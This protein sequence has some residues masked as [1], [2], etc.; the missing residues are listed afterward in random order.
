MP[1]CTAHRLPTVSLLSVTCS[2]MECLSIEITQYLVF[3]FAH[4]PLDVLSLALASKTMYRKVLGELGRENAYDRDQHCAVGGVVYCVKNKAWRAA[5]LALER[6]YGDPCAEWKVRYKSTRTPLAEA[7]AAGV[8]GLV[9]CLLGVRRV[10]P[11]AARNAAIRLASLG[12]HTGTV[13]VLL[14]DGRADP[15]ADYNYAIRRAAQNGHATTVRVLLRDPRVDP[16]AKNNW[17]IRMA[18]SAGHTVVVRL[19]LADDRVDPSAGTNYA[20]RMACAWGRIETVR[21]LL[22]DVR[23]DAAADNGYALRMAR[24]NGHWDVVRLLGGCSDGCE[25]AEGAKQ[26]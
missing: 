20:V 1:T 22:E 18:A 2:R 14:A 24:E 21:V 9:V 25:N 10:D 23:V 16:S 8:E 17:A 26:G 6:G 7:A 4:S 13:R 3:H 19:L 5:R 12:G 11:G 15:A